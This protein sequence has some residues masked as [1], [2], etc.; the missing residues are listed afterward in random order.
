MAGGGRARLALA[1]LG[2]VDGVEIET[3]ASAEDLAARAERH[4]RDGA[5]RL[6]VA[7]GDGSIHAVIPAVA[8]TPCAL[9]IVPLGRGNDLARALGLPLSPRPAVERA[10]AAQAR[11]IDLGESVGRLFA[12]VAAIGFDAEVAR[13]VRDRRTGIL[14][15]LIYPYAVLR[16]LAAFRPMRFRIDHDGGT[17]EGPAWM[18]AIANSPI[19]GGGMRIAPEA[20]LRDG[21][22]DVVIV[23]GMSKA[24]ALAVFPRVYRGSHVRHP[25]VVV[26]RTTRAEIRCD[27]PVPCFADGEPIQDVGTDGAT[28]RVRG[29]ALRV[30]A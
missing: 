20:D 11:P 30:L 16:T 15:R 13:F 26:R 14:G 17:D 27:R 29:A 4:V 28:F 21:A 18:V 5:R 3:A 10:L 7:G 12:G 9:G 22:F 2:A 23:R 19:Y 1:A 8:G 24:R 6:L 25:A